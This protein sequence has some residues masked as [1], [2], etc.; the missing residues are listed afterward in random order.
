M[1][2]PGLQGVTTSTKGTDMIKVHQRASS[3]G[4]GGM[5]G[6]PVAVHGEPAGVMTVART[7]MPTSQRREM[8]LV[9]RCFQ[10]VTEMFAAAA[11]GRSGE[12]A[13]QAI[14]SAFGQ[15]FKQRTLPLMRVHAYVSGT[16]PEIQGATSAAFRELR[17]SLERLT[18]PPPAQVQRS[19]GIGM[20]MTATTAM[21]LQA[22]DNRWTSPCHGMSGKGTGT[23]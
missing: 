23:A 14:E 20:L 19:S 17:D 1:R 4:A 9:S 21:D 2:S 11:A 12:D 18:G 15:L 16:D 8:V 13:L 7:R 3:T 22:I 10:R 5:F 6:R